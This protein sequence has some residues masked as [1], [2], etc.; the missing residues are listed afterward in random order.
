MQRKYWRINQHYGA[1]MTHMN[2]PPHIRLRDLRIRKGFETQKELCAHARS[3]GI[4]IDLRRYRNIES[5]RG[6]L[7]AHRVVIKGYF[8]DRSLDKEKILSIWDLL[9]QD[10]RQQLTSL[11]ASLLQEAPQPCAPKFSGDLAEACH[12]AK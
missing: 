12:K 3:L 10:K 7:L 11:A 1:I 4:T 2:R 5:G 8:V 6:Q 9:P